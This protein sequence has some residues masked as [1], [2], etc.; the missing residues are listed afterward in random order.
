MSVLL[1]CHAANDLVCFGG[2]GERTA[3]ALLGLAMRIASELPEAAAGAGAVLACRDRYF[4]CAALL[5]ALQ[6]GYRVMLPPNGQPETIRELAR[7]ADAL[8]H[9]VPGGAGLSVR[10]LEAG[11][12]AGQAGSL[13]ADLLERPI[14]LF[15]SGS[16]GVPEGHEKRLALLVAEAC[17]HLSQF[18]LAG[19]RIVAGVPPHHIYGL[20]FG[21][22]VPLLGGGSVLR[23]TPLFPRELSA[24]LFEHH[25]D[26]LVSVP[27]QLS[28][29]AEDHDLELPALRRVFCSAGPLTTQAAALLSARGVT[30]T[31]ILGSTETG[32]I[33]YRERHEAAWS[34]LRAVH[35]T[36]DPEGV[37][38]VDAP[39]LSDLQT[40][41]SRTADRAELCAG[42]F[43][44][45]GRADAVTKIA[46]RRVDLGDVESVLRA[47]PGVRDARVLAVEGKGVRGLTLWA[48]VESHEAQAPELL[49]AALHEHFDPVTVPKRFR[50]VASLPRNE[51]GK[52]T[53]AA[54]LALFDTWELTFESLPGGDVR[55]VV[56]RNTGFVRGHFEG[57]P[58]LPGVV[59]LKHVA[60]T[61]TRRRFPELRA[62]ARVTRVK[63]K[64]M[65]LPGEA[66][67]LTLERKSPLQVQ[68][69]MRVGSEPACSGI[70][71][72]RDNQPSLVE[73]P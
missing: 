43:R 25:A 5:G 26:V 56:P 72:F 24:A 16:T 27:P 33:A 65:V 50:R 51:S 46:G 10:E 69:A 19:R 42:G 35:V 20:L 53:R 12:G 4:F 11:L 13:R 61:E 32:G 66:L 30:I 21:V 1:G 59:Q 37:L 14:V 3:A 62:L 28:A 58:I 64:R 23:S 22:L 7:S 48:V 15:T 57:D 70:F 36:I 39:W 34:P 29:L 73:V 52:V 38:C 6:R 68:F 17:A 41:P 71:H 31:E 9:D 18:E 2:E 47:V 49:R 44:H 55:V 54:L 45:L 63:F 60:L 8:L 40:R 67:L